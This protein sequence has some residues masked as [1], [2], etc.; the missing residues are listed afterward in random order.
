MET[1]I[2]VMTLVGFLVALYISHLNIF[3]GEDEK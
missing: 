2:I 1:F 3:K